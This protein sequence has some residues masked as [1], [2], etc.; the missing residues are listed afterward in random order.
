MT[1]HD[2]YVRFTASAKER[3]LTKNNQFARGLSLQTHQASSDV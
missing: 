1:G 3:V 2:V